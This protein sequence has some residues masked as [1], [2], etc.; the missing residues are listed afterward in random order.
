MNKNLK[1]IIFILA[2]LQ[3]VVVS[4]VRAQEDNSTLRNGSTASSYEENMKQWQ[5]MSEKQREAIRQKVHAIDSGQ[6][7][8]LLE[9]AKQFKQLP[10]EEQ[11]RIQG[12]FQKFRELP[13]EKK[14]FLRERN[15]RFQGFS[16]EK[17][18]ELRRGVRE[19]RERKEDVRGRREDVRDR[20]EDG[21]DRRE[22]RRERREDI[23]GRGPGASPDRKPAKGKVPGGGGQRGGGKPKKIN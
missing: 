17:I 21:F 12:N 15:K 1:Y 14:E 22:D 4:V 7:Q 5:S 11:A 19:K 23:G 9:N 18:T 10:R 3:M 13:N 20:R 2:F 6:R 8:T 16:P